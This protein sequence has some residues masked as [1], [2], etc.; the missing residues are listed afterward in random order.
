MDS[1]LRHYQKIGWESNAIFYLIQA[2]KIDKR[3]I[4]SF[5]IRNSETLDN[6]ISKT[7]WNSTDNAEARQDNQ[8]GKME[9]E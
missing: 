9:V 3:R 6:N 1:I 7:S 4:L 8:I 2:N 5:R